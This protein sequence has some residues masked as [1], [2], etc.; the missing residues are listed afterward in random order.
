MS[1]YVVRLYVAVDFP[2]FRKDSARKYFAW[3]NTE[4]FGR[5]E[6]VSNA[7][8]HIMTREKRKAPS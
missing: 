3:H 2:L 6:I 1:F 8:I 7:L 4:A 5:L